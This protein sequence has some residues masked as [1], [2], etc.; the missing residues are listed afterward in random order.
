MNGKVGI[1]VEEARGSD[2][3]AADPGDERVVVQL[4]YTQLEGDIT[5]NE[6]G[7]ELAHVFDHNGPAMCQRMSVKHRC[8]TALSVEY[9]G[10]L[11]L[12]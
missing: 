4:T 10:S 12:N 1:V 9:D 5:Y 8:L 11:E 2:E 3:A 6:E 7:A